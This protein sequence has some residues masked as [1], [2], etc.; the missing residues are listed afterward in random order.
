MDISPK[1]S[2]K[3]LKG[4]LKEAKIVGYTNLNVEIANKEEE[5]EEEETEEEREK[6]KKKEEEKEEVVSANFR[7]L[8][9]A[10]LKYTTERVIY[11]LMEIA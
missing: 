10:E 9:L 1:V 2:S 7:L 11:L 5:E 3:M 8:T 6:R 4:A